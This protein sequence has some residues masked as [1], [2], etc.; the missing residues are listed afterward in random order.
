MFLLL[1]ELQ[2]ISLVKCHSFN[3]VDIETTTMMSPGLI[4]LQWGLNLMRSLLFV[5]SV[6]DG[7]NDGGGGA[8]WN[9]KIRVEI[10]YDLIITMYIKSSN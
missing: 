8:T 5:Y 1:S 9:R 3:G 10:Y 6:Q 7:N 4:F 2:K